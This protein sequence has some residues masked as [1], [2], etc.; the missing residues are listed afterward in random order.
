MKKTII[1]I[2]SVILIA[3]LIYFF[4]F[5]NSNINSISEE[6]IE[7]KDFLKD[8]QAVIYLSS[9][10]DQDMDGKGISYAIFIDKNEKAHGYKMNGLELGGIGISDNKKEILLESKNNIKFIG[11]DFKNYKMKYQHTGDQRLYLKKPGLFVNIYNSGSNSSTGNYDSNVIYGNQKQIH[12]G[13]I[14]HYLISSG[15]NTDE[16]LVLTQDIDKNEHSLKKLLFNDST[17]HL[18]DVT[19]IN[20]DKNMSYASYSSILSDSNFYYT[21]LVE[22]DNSIKGKVYLLRID[23]KSLKQDLILLSSEE[24]STASIP[25]TKNNSAYLHNNELFFI[26]GLGEVITFNT[27]TNAVN[28]KFKIDYHVTDGVRYN[29]QTYFEDD[30]LY[31]LRYNEKQEHKYSIETY[32]LTTGK[33]IKTATIKDMDQI[34]TSVKGGKSIYAYDFKMLQPNK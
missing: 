30:Q 11:E 33:K 20:L 26:N 27:Q 13:N 25:F 18:E 7:K 9:T 2:L 29:E 32:S 16:V 8:K 5:K 22:N 28:P 15:V 4:F 31:V 1:L 19:T 3:A 34:I 12:K 17:M 14:P 21:I 6:D 10:A 23:K 24:N